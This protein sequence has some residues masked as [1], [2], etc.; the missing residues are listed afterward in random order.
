MKLLKIWD[1]GIPVNYGDYLYIKEYYAS[2]AIYHECLNYPKSI[3]IQNEDFSLENNTKVKKVLV[4]N[5]A[6][7]TN[8]HF[9]IF[10]K[11]RGIN[12]IEVYVPLSY[13][14]KN[15]AEKLFP[16]AKMF[17]IFLSTD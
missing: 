9:E 12:N 17:F 11:L 4:G 13:G 15:Y 2:T 14:D 8:F 5:S 10:D 1:I 16:M 6:T 7:Q 3:L